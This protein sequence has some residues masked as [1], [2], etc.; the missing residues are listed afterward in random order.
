MTIEQFSRQTYWYPIFWY[1]G[2]TIVAFI[3][4]ILFWKR[5]SATA[6]GS[7]PG[8]SATWKF[9]GAAAI[10]VVVLLVFSF[11]NPLKPFSDYK[12]I[13]ILYSDQAHP[14]S[15]TGTTVFKITKSELSAYDKSVPFDPDTLV[16]QLIPDDCMYGLT[17]E[18]TGD[19]F[20]TTKPIPKGNYYML[21]RSSLT[22]Q[23]KVRTLPVG[24][25]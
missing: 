6:G 1:V 13:L 21:F 9:T 20:S 15:S 19:S 8:V 12:N 18:L 25:Q 4:A 5:G 3:A 10:F 2:A 23:V 24:E 14:P 11:I 16:I 22:G 17:P 7:V